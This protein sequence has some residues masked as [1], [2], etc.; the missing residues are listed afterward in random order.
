MRWKHGVST[1]FQ[2]QFAGMLPAID[3]AYLEVTG[4]E[5]TLTSGNDGQ[6]MPG[7]RHYK[8]LAGDF[9]IRHPDWQEALTRE[10]NEAA[11]RWKLTPEQNRG[12]VKALRRWLNGAED[13]D[14]PFNV[15]LEEAKLHF[16]IEYDPR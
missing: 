15:V 9:R 13:K 2:P 5:A 12:L 14:R 10:L 8:G 3:A 6:H 1:Y 4:R 7:S 16:H 11:G